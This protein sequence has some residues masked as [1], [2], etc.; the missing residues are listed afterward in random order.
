MAGRWRRVWQVGVLAVPLFHGPLWALDW[1]AAAQAGVAAPAA[2][3]PRQAAPAGS[4]SSL[5]F[6]RGFDLDTGTDFALSLGGIPLNL[7]S[8][9]RG[10]GALDT[11]LIIPETLAGIRYRKGPYRGDQGPFATAGS[12]EL[13]VVERL[14]APE[15]AFTY[16]GATE[17][18]YARVLW[19]ESRQ[20]SLLTTYALE[21]TH[22]YRPWD[23]LGPSVKLN[24]FY[25][26]APATGRDWSLTVL[27]SHEKADGGSAT[28]ERDLPAGFKDHYGDL[29]VGDGLHTQRIY[30]G[31]QKRIE[32]RP[33]VT[34]CWQVYAGASAQTHWVNNT[35]F[36]RDD[37]WGD[38]MEQGDRRSFLGTELRR[39]WVL[40]AGAVEWTHRV[41][42][43]ARL[44]RLESASVHGTYARERLQPLFEAEGELFHGAL[45]AHSVARWAE[46]WRGFGAI[47]LD[48]Q[49]NQVSL[50]TPW[51]PRNPGSP[52]FAPGP[53]T[54]QRRTS[55]LVSP[56]FGLAYSP[57]EGT[58]FRASWGQGFRQ[59]NALR[60]PQALIR[61][62]SVEVAAQTR[63]L[64]PWDTSLTLWRLELEAE[65][66][67]DPAQAAFRDG[68][69]ARHQG[70]D[71]YHH[72]KWGRWRAEACLGWSRA[73]FRNA[74]PGHDRVPNSIPRTAVLA[75]AWK[76]EGFTVEAKVR[77]LGA[78]AL[79]PDNRVSADRQRAL[80][81][82]LE[83]AWGPWAASL[84]VINAFSLRKHNQEYFYVSAFPDGLTASPLATRA[85][86][87]SDPQAIRLEL[88]RRF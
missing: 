59:G 5:T 14:A 22:S 24:A 20:G 23:Q 30:L 8:T 54:P 82:K 81:V 29:H 50:Q 78:Y 76:G 39:Q 70:L 44:D 71:W 31:F 63:L 42:L 43:Q 88:R 41:G 34:D 6:A 66:L 16:G 11:G 4:R 26:L 10:P 65:A 33:G 62:H 72:L 1:D 13:R 19:A 57:R 37:Y 2:P 56:K 40:Q 32:R 27:A 21:A 68:P 86:K 61:A 87:P 64:G 74:L 38:Q 12:A 69:P 3:S 47:R 58:E 18:R 17:D 52:L 53:W 7:P 9:V 25:R 48:T 35:Y 75:L 15:L 55:T 85:L 67:F 60:E 77:S 28:P 83:R 36:L 84:E 49:R 73:R 46:G 80:E 79:T 45:F 51:D